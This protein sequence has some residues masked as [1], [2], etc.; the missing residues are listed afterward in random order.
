[1]AGARKTAKRTFNC[2]TASAGHGQPNEKSDT[3]FDNRVSLFYLVM[4]KCD[5]L[6]LLLVRLLPSYSTSAIS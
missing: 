4:S 1:M 5:S 3:W 2:F 6:F